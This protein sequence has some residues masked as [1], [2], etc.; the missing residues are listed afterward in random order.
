MTCSSSTDHTVVTP[1]CL[2]FISNCSVVARGGHVLAARHADSGENHLCCSDYFENWMGSERRVQ[3]LCYTTVQSFDLYLG[4]G[5]LAAGLIVL[6]FVLG[7]YAA[8]KRRLTKLAGVT[9]LQPVACSGSR[10]AAGE[11]SPWRRGGGSVSTAA[12]HQEEAQAQLAESLLSYAR[13]EAP[14]YKSLR[15]DCAHE[16]QRAFGF[17]HDSVA[18][19]LEH[20]DSL[21]VSDLSRN[22]GDFNLAV[23]HLHAKIV[24]PIERW[25]EH[26]AYG[27]TEGAYSTDVMTS[28]ILRRRAGTGA[29]EGERSDA[30]VVTAEGRLR[31]WVRLSTSQQAN[32]CFTQTAPC[33]AV[34]ALVLCAAA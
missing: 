14:R 18:N 31:T 16:L 13:G 8:K 11:N 6:S 17:Q 33:P 15:H 23:E 10:S 20:L 5:T 7:C 32:D 30:A 9:E 1:Q 2:D 29:A 19:Q 27:A 24:G 28:P 4:L 25:R 22:N 34:K 21:L 26:I 3:P 12:N